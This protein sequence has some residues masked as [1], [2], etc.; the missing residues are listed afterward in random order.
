MFEKTL[1]YVKDRN[2]YGAPMHR[3]SSVS[4]KL[5]SVWNKLEAMRALLYT[6]T[7]LFDDGRKDGMLSTSCK[8]WICET[9]FECCTILLQMWGGSGMMDSTGINRYFRDARTNMVA[10]AATE[11]HNSII[12]RRVLGLN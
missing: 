2:L 3:L 4:D 9:A 7:R 12:A 1:S 10:E 6:T 11:M 8:A 5:A